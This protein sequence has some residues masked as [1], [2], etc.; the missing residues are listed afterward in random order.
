M[1]LVY[2]FLAVLFVSGT[3]L[4]CPNLSGEWTCVGRDSEKANVKFT[5]ITKE[6]ISLLLITSD[7]GTKVQTS[8]TLVLDGGKQK[9]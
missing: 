4:A 7:E 2:S 5:S 6:D 1:K 3:A 9:N 8:D